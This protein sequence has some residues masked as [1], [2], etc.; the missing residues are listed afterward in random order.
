MTP[1]RQPMAL[2]VIRAPSTIVLSER[3]QVELRG[4]SISDTNSELVVRLIVVGTGCNVG[5]PQCQNAC[6]DLPFFRHVTSSQSCARQWDNL[7][8]VQN[9]AERFRHLLS[10]SITNCLL[11]ASGKSHPDQRPGVAITEMVVSATAPDTF[12][13][14]LAHDCFWHSQDNPLPSDFTSTGRL[15]T[16]GRGQE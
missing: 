9:V 1:P 14:N 11:R 2:I 5:S 7:P 4:P 16:N 13:G 12:C 10:S 6:G 15:A 3:Q 8:R